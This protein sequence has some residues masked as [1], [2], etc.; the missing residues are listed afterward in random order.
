MERGGEYLMRIIANLFLQFWQKNSFVFAKIL[1]I[2]KNRH[3][4]VLYQLSKTV[5]M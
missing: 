1:T 5:N 4:M 2:I 3:I